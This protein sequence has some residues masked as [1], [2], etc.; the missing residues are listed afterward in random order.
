M[1]LI[2]GF[3]FIGTMAIIGTGTWLLI[4]RSRRKVK[5]NSAIVRLGFGGTQVFLKPGEW[6]HC[7]PQLH[8]CQEFTFRPQE[9]EVQLTQDNYATTADEYRVTGSIT[10]TVS[11]MRTADAILNACTSSADGNPWSASAVDMMHS[12]LTVFLKDHFGQNTFSDLQSEEVDNSKLRDRLDRVV[13][14]KGGVID[15]L[16]LGPVTETERPQ[17]TDD[18]VFNVTD[19]VRHAQKQIDE[20]QEAHASALANLAGNN[21]DVTKQRMEA[22]EREA[23]DKIAKIDSITR[24]QEQDMASVQR[25]TA[26]SMK[27]TQDNITDQLTGELDHSQKQIDGAEETTDQNKYW[28]TKGY[29]DRKDFETKKTQDRETTERDIEENKSHEEH[30]GRRVNQTVESLKD[31]AKSQVD[32]EQDNCEK[33]SKALT[34]QEEQQNKIIREDER[35][36]L[37]DLQTQQE[38]I[39]A[40]RESAIAAMDAVENETEQHRKDSEREEFPEN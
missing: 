7:V 15:K 20:D 28:T 33:L 6:V 3:V 1:G 10:M 22:N 21:A 18:S 12:Q 37:S 39:D 5:S 32:K 27:H 2:L 26:M 9:L 40:G 25:Q 16:V 36:A 11:T 24:Q 23:A 31:L 38:K 34:E 4:H 30:E 35:H 17:N 14:H 29:R 19:K 8:N 13:E